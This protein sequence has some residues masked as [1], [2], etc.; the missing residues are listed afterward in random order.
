[1]VVNLAGYKLL[2]HSWGKI[3]RD[4]DIKI[5]HNHGYKTK[6][7]KHREPMN[8]LRPSERFDRYYIYGKKE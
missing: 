4:H 3:N 5:L 7:I 1:M 6:V 8:P 2:A